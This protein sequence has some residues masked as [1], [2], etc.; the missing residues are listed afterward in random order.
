[1][2]SYEHDSAYLMRTRYYRMAFGETEQPK[3]KQH[4]VKVAPMPRWNASPGERGSRVYYNNIAWLKERLAD[5]IRYDDIV[6]RKAKNP[7]VRY[8]NNEPYDMRK[9]EEAVRMYNDITGKNEPCIS[10]QDYV[11]YLKERKMKHEKSES[12]CNV[13]RD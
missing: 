13:G 1:M 8:Y 5:D 6:K 3:R 11:T 7:C 9:G 12:E 2:D 4:Y 10:A